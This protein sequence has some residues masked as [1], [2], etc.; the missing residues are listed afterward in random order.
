MYRQKQF[1]SLNRRACGM[2]TLTP[3]NLKFFKT[4]ADF[5]RWLAKSHA[6]ETVLWVGFYKKDSGRPSITYHDALDEALCYGWI[7]GI[8][9]SVD[10]V[11][12]TV[13]FT[14]RKPGSI[15]SLV[16]IRRVNELIKLERMMPP[17]LKAFEARDEKK[18]QQYSYENHLRKLNGAYEKQFRANKKAWEFFQT[19]APW[20]R[21]TSSWWVV[22]AK[23]EATRQ[24]RLQQLMDYSEK[25]ER[26]P[27]LRKKE[28]AD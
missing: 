12:Y 14:P 7:D 28:A 10:A 24:R 13:R 25:G 4:A 27:Q 16:N 18:S 8:R 26:I 11:S 9:K 6:S 22:S 2:P 1:S 3:A 21:R 17:G 20:Y 5:R 19:Q 23:Q 15:W